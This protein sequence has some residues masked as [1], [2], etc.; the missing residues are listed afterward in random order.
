MLMN[1]FRQLGWVM[2][3]FIAGSTLATSHL[4]RIQ[5]PALTAALM[6]R[7]ATLLADYGSFQIL[8]TDFLPKS[9]SGWEWEKSSSRIELKS[10][11]LD[12]RRAEG[13]AL[14]KT[15]GQ[16]SGKRLHL[17][18]FALPIKSE[19]VSKLQDLGVRI[20]NYFPRNA[21]LVY[22]DAAALARLQAW[23]RASPVVQWDGEYPAAFEFTP[24]RCRPRTNPHPQPPG[25]IPSRY[26]WLR[27]RTQTRRR[28]R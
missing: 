16:F 13:G 17:I 28:S 27:T 10:G 26:N 7:G 23:A 18:Q 4:L 22:G 25:W 3:L 9:A 15:L 11:A 20:V 2:G 24:G 5:D 14:R 8:A 6:D 21:Y 1:V 19:W 12:T